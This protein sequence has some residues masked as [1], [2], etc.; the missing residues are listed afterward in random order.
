MLNIWTTDGYHSYSIRCEE[1]GEKFIFAKENVDSVKYVIDKYFREA[2]CKAWAFLPE[3]VCWE[4]DEKVW[5]NFLQTQ[6][7][8]F[9]IIPNWIA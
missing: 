4:V 3:W 9:T 2:G 8:K 1:T 7:K 6:L 5:L